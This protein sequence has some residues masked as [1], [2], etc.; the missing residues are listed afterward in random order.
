MRFE[1]VHLNFMFN[2]CM[3]LYTALSAVRVSCIK[4]QLMITF[5]KNITLK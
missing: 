2:D 1:L 5:S 3:Y 4:I